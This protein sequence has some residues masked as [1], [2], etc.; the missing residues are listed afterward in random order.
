MSENDA[1][2]FRKET[3]WSSMM[4]T[5]N[6]GDVPEATVAAGGEEAGEK[7]KVAEKPAEHMQAWIKANVPGAH[8]NLGTRETTT[9]A[10]ASSARLQRDSGNSSSQTQDDG[11]NGQTPVA[12]PRNTFKHRRKDSPFQVWRPGSLPKRQ[13][14]G[15]DNRD[16]G[17]GHPERMQPLPDPVGGLRTMD[18][19]APQ[20]PA[21]KQIKEVGDQQLAQS[22]LK[23]VAQKVP[24]F[25]H[26]A[27][28]NSTLEAMVRREIVA[29][30]QSRARLW[31]AAASSLP[32][33]MVS[34]AQGTAQYLQSVALPSVVISAPNSHPLPKGGSGKNTKQQK[35]CQCKKTKCLKL[36]CP[37]FAEGL[38]CGPRCNC[39]DCFNDQQ[40]DKLVKEAREKIKEKNPDAFEPK[41]RVSA[42]R[43]HQA[44]HSEGGV[45]APQVRQTLQHQTGCKCTKT[46]CLKRYCECY[47]AGVFC[48]TK[49]NCTNCQNTEDNPL[50]SNVHG[51]L[52]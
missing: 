5:H 15:G 47:A 14:A 52:Q 9:P 16:G 42:Q 51:A 10:P 19:E 44:P 1:H 22:I 50:L 8:V 23:S 31:E 28:S 12:E 41:V 2:L 39:R 37:C 6:F 32:T 40:Y 21:L 26:R 24:S 27:A 38:Y 45:N 17:T 49:C 3:P 4:K 43:M 7:S 30:E 25:Q 11:G 18:R 35:R 33:P 13:K 46:S 34:R 29:S 20:L 48:G 36:Y